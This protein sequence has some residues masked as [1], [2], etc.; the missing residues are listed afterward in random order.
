MQPC[1][2]QH[3]TWGLEAFIIDCFG[4]GMIRG[5]PEKIVGAQ[6]AG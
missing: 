3:D 2:R 1:M 4:P 5:L 6:P